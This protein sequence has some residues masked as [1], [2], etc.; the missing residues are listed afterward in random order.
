M[1]KV[2]IAGR[3]RVEIVDTPDLEPQ[4]NWAVVKIH[5]NP[6]CTKYKGWVAGTP[7]AFLGHEAGGWGGLY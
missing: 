4:D 2:T 1:R 5:A 3:H 6:L 7:A